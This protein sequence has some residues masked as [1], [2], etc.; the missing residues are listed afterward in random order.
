MTQAFPPLSIATFNIRLGLQQGLGAIAD[1]ID[2]MGAPDIV[3]LQEVGQHWTMGP[4]GD[5]TAHLAQSLD[6]PHHLFTPTIERNTD[7]SQ[8]AYYGHAILSRWPITD[9]RCTDLPQRDDE[10]RVLTSALIDRPSG[11]FQLL[12]TH[13]SHRNTDR[14]AQGEVLVYEASE[15]RCPSLPT[16]V[17]GD[18]N[19][20]TND[21]P[22]PWLYRLLSGFVDA[23]ERLQRPTFP[24]SAPTRRIDYI[25]ARGADLQSIDV[26]DP[27]GAS[28]HRA[29]LSHWGPPP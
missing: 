6:Y 24:A 10:P 7:A 18:L 20:D 26:I 8:P 17:V 14:P 2:S 28:D 29:L 22:S 3:A 25:L 12:S 9:P 23:D 5:T 13:L 15:Q 19:A 27:H 16:F 4:G 1:L 11:P 21:P